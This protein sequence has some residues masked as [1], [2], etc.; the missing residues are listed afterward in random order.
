VAQIHLLKIQKKSSNTSQ[1]V[2][3]CIMSKFYVHEKSQV[4]I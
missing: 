3:K 4:E 2:L 1:T